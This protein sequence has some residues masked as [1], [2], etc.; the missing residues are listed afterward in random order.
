MNFY[1]RYALLC[2]ERGETPSGV[3]LKI[4]VTKA[5]VNYWKDGHIPKQQTLVKLADYFGVPFDYLI[6][7]SEN[8]KGDVNG[9]DIAK[10]ALF[11][12]DTDVTDEMWE[13]AK[14]Y[15]EFIKQKHKKG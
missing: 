9:N 13:E 8:R 7:I 15:A 2:K 1:E 11:G 4:G 5:A 12:G 6:G 3:G 14:Q 10:V